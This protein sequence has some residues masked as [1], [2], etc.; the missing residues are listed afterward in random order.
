[1]AKKK[2]K[3]K[4]KNR[5]NS[6]DISCQFIIGTHAAL[7]TGVA[8]SKTFQGPFGPLVIKIEGLFFCIRSGIDM[9]QNFQGSI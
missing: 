7:I 1:M 5:S 9:S 8:T 3:T 2:Q 6:D 4:H